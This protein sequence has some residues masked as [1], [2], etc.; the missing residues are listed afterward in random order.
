MNNYILVK[1][2]PVLCR[3]IVLWGRWFSKTEQRQVMLTRCRNNVTISTVFLGIDHNFSGVGPPVLW[4]TMAFPNTDDCLRATS[5]EEAIANH[6]E[7]VKSYGGYKPS[8]VSF[9]SLKRM[10]R[11]KSSR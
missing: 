8:A 4:E 11:K 5:H 2:K 9:K 7:I 3:D 10:F 1:N 6:N